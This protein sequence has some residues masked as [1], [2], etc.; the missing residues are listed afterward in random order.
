MTDILSLPKCLRVSQVAELLDVD[1]ATV[2][3]LAKTGEIGCYRV[4]GSIRIGEN[5]YREYL[6]RIESCRDQRPQENGNSSD[7]PGEPA[8]TLT[9][10]SEANLSGFR[11]KRRA[12]RA[13]AKRSP[14]LREKP[15]STPPKG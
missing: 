5:H 2:Y 13:L 7:V 15:N 11:S 10:T 4:G 12:R 1:A 6:E 8:G 3:R 14:I 9:A